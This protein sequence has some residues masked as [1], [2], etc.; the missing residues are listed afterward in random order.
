VTPDELKNAA[1]AEL[2]E[3]GYLP[4]SR[5]DRMAVV[6]IVVDAVEPLIR[7][8]ERKQVCAYIRD[9]VAQLTGKMIHR[10]HVLF[11]LD[12][13]DGPAESA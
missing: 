10:N 11:L 5:T 3:Q 7:A 13:I 2:T 8:D 12:L 4:I 1:Y 6:D 9:D